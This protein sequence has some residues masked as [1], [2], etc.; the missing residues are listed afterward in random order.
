MCNWS[1]GPFLPPPRRRHNRNRRHRRGQ[2]GRPC[3]T[4]GAPPSSPTPT[5][6][7]HHSSSCRCCLCPWG[8]SCC[9]HCSLPIDNA[10]P[11]PPLSPPPAPCAAVDK[12]LPRGPAQWLLRLLV[13]RPARLLWLLLPMCELERLLRLLLLS[14]P[15]A[16]SLKLLP[17]PSSSLLELLPICELE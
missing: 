10:A 1:R 5:P 11:P 9:L 16:L 2:G 4:H 15:P 8:C 17:P 13:C 12:L 3:G 14:T 7:P 6:F